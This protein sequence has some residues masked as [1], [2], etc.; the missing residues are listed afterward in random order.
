MGDLLSIKLKNAAKSVKPL[1]SDKEMEPTK[2]K[3]SLAKNP[4]GQKTIKFT[5]LGFLGPDNSWT[6]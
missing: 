6:L 3:P 1:S 2:Y 5:P 4:S